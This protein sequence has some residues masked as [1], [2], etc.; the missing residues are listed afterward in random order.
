[1]EENQTGQK[2]TTETDPLTTEEPEIQAPPKANPQDK[3]IK[4]LLPVIIFLLIF[5]IVGGSYIFIKSRQKPGPPGPTPTPPVISEKIGFEKFASEEEFVA[6]LE[7]VAGA[8]VEFFGVPRMM[9]EGR[10]E[11]LEMPAPVAEIGAAPERVSE[12]TVQVRG[13]DEPDIVKTDG[14]EIYFSSTFPVFFAPG[15]PVPILEERILPPPERGETKVIKAFPPAELVKETEI[16]KSGNLLLEKDI[17]V[18]FTDDNKIYGFDVSDPKL[19]TEKWKVELEDNNFLVD[20][21]LYQGKIYFLTSTRIDTVRPC[22]IVPLT[23]GG[24]QFSI[25]CTD[26]YHPLINVPVDVTYTAFIVNPAT[27]EIDKSV[28]FIGS[29]GASVLYMSKNALYA[30]YTYYEDVIDFLYQFFLEKGEDLVPASL[31]EKL[32]NLKDYDISAQ[33][34]LVEFQTIYEQYLNSLSNDERLRIENEFTNRME[35]YTQEH[36]RELEKTGIVKIS[37]DNFDVLATGSIPGRPLNQFSL[38]EYQNYLRIATTVGERMFSV[39]E[40]ANDVYVLSTALE[41]VGSVIN[42]GLGERIYSV[43]FIE[44]KGYLVTFREIDPFF[45]LDLS[46]PNQPKVKGELKIPGYSSYLHPI[47][48]DKILGVGKEGSQ[49]K[50]SLFDVVSPDNPSEIS[51]YTLDEFWSDILNTHHAFLLDK[52]HS[53][54]FLPGSRGG[55]VFSYQGNELKLTKAVADISARRAIYINDY[56]YIIGD[57]KLVVLNEVDW[58]QINQLEF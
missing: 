39:G 23:F 14:K 55:Y 50:I 16:E 38:D 27:G 30:T 11:A 25:R 12:T 29:S 28:S 20:A 6:Y 51:K 44:D 9:L 35:D 40:S 46:D 34:K 57:N 45:V 8:A 31:V 49:I 56:M 47:T 3:I 15:R 18:I 36:M 54:F 48:K 13:I 19:P 22:P 41:Q 17:L 42:L 26:I 10:F 53:V 58:E 21:R 7:E 52:D 24:Q 1:M 32:K 2:P 33:A 43:R 5:I 4:I 37:L